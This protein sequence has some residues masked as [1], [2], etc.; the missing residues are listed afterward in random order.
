MEDSNDTNGG[1]SS[2]AL[3]VSS[4][5]VTRTRGSNS[6]SPTE[7]GSTRAPGSETDQSPLQTS[8]GVVD[9][10][11]QYMP[12]AL[13]GR[14]PA[15][16]PRAEAIGDEDN[17]RTASNVDTP[18]PGGPRTAVKVA[19]KTPRTAVKDAAGTMPKEM[20]ESVL[21]AL[22]ENASVRLDAF[23]ASADG[24]RIA[25]AANEDDDEELSTHIPIP[26]DDDGHSHHS[27]DED[28]G[29]E[30]LAAAIERRVT[31]P[32][33]WE[34]TDGPDPCLNTRH[35][36][37]GV[38]ISSS[39][40]PPPVRGLFGAP[41]TKSRLSLPAV[42]LRH[43]PGV[44][45]TPAISAPATQAQVYSNGVI[46]PPHGQHAYVRP[47]TYGR[48]PP[49]TAPD[50]QRTPEGP[51][52]VPDAH[53]S[54]QSHVQ[55]RDG[56]PVLVYHPSGTTVAFNDHGVLI[57]LNEDPDGPGMS[58]EAF[59]TH[60]G[61]S[62]HAPP[63]WHGT[64]V[65]APT[66]QHQ[67]GSGGHVY[68]CPSF[69]ATTEEVASYAWACSD[70]GANVMA[71]QI[72]KHIEPN[73]YV[74][75]NV[76]AEYQADLRSFCINSRVRAARAADA[77]A[78]RGGSS[79]TTVRTP[80]G[81]HI[82][83]RHP[84][85]ATV[86]FQHNG[87]M[88][89]MFSSS[90]EPG[91]SPTLL[92]GGAQG[93]LVRGGTVVLNETGYSAP[94]NRAAPSARQGMMATGPMAPPPAR[95]TAIKPGS[96]TA[97][98]PPYGD[99]PRK[100][101]NRSKVPRPK[102]RD[103]IYRMEAGMASPIAKPVQP[104][105]TGWGQPHQHTAGWGHTPPPPALHGGA[106]PHRPVFGPP[107]P[108]ASIAEL[109]RG[110]AEM[111][112]L[113]RSHPQSTQ[114]SSSSSN[115]IKDLSKLEPFDGT[116]E[117]FK[118]FETNLER[119]AAVNNLEHTLDPDYF[120]SDLFNVTDNKIMYF[121][122]EKAVKGNTLAYSH[123]KKAPKQDGNKAYF[124][125]RDAFVFSAQAT[126]ALSLMK[127]TNFRIGQGELVSAFCLRLRELF[128]EL[129]ELEGD[130]AFVFN[131]T[132]R[133][134]Y[135]LTSIGAEVE[136]E[137]SYTY[138]T[139][140]MNRGTMTFELAIADL[141]SRCE[142][143]RAD[144]LLHQAR[145][146][147]RRHGN[148]GHS[149]SNNLDSDLSDDSDSSDRQGLVST[150]NK[151]HNQTRLTGGGDN[152]NTTRGT[153]CLVKGCSEL[154]DLP[155]CKLHYSSLVCGKS[156]KLELQDGYG[157]ATYDKVAGKTVYPKSVPARLLERIQRKRR[158]PKRGDSQRRR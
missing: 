80:D 91:S 44:E 17:R 81:D 59:T 128:E 109:Y 32:S 77:Q 156:S 155:I 149:S 10:L 103:T 143:A 147:S 68:G 94:G 158:D 152:S 13:G 106:T 33:G 146:R 25:A 84:A 130:H 47:D 120:G 22:N 144:A 135:L 24:S 26:E 86:L 88:M 1:G 21:A 96:Q 38:S 115:L 29:N 15:G 87:K 100:R 113:V 46:V 110:E 35:G 49:I 63:A 85:E 157:E 72:P 101:I 64:Q 98:K 48:V 58:L 107:R 119:V 141:E 4:S 114:H 111:N 118:S 105:V 75:G 36:T 104:S 65:P 2:S 50:F 131:D 73:L 53:N 20:V 79:G 19:T 117:S 41:S 148:L 151:R 154:C 134:G 132:Q 83:V 62:V 27:S 93:R 89:L 31:T 97:V 108:P 40:N 124:A 76:L 57:L 16:G 5:N 60:A 136:L 23:L 28:S 7:L 137:A 18:S 3:D 133:L 71:H 139:S 95:R 39:S 153:K 123:F 12:V 11:L 142:Q 67:V 129:E 42:M 127:L 122:L 102:R 138:I 121:L 56:Q 51:Y 30:G 99:D 55:G 116:Q 70:L 90:G 43:P 66:L 69:A 37:V 125:L 6:F 140:E 150:Q 14:T 34:Y 145:P 82:I 54:I 78:G 61:G 92:D 126:G 52:V 74:S 45:R 9:A 112:P 8:G